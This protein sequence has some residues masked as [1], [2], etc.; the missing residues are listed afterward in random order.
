MKLVV[1]FRRLKQDI[2]HLLFKYMAP[3]YM[4]DDRRFSTYTIGAYSYGAPRILR[5]DDTTQLII[6]KYCSFAKDV[7]LVLGGG[8]RQD[9]VTTYPFSV[10][11]N[12]LK[13]CK[14]HPQSKGDIIIGHDVWVGF[15]ATVLSGVTIKNGAVVAANSTVTKDVPAYAIVGGTP[16]RVIKYRFDEQTIER[17]QALAW[18]DWPHK[19]IIQRGEDMLND[20]IASFLD[21]YEK[22]NSNR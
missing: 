8:H 22:C 21:K 2:Y 15:G 3:R 1:F 6:G 14:G 10:F 19:L 18:W 12:E 16:A 20:D 13:H 4:C 11:H 5:W 7:K 17:L 9:W